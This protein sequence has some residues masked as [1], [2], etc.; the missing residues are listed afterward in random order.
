MLFPIAFVNG[1]IIFQIRTARGTCGPVG[2]CDI[3][4]VI[5]YFVECRGLFNNPASLKSGPSKGGYWVC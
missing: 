5:S 1:V 4:Y 3:D 2:S